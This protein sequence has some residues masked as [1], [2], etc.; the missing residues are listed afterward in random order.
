MTALTFFCHC[1]PINTPTPWVVVGIVFSSVEINFHFICY[2]CYDRWLEML[3][4]KWQI[5][6]ILVAAAVSH[7]GRTVPVGDSDIVVSAV[8]GVV[9]RTSINSEEGEFK[10]QY[11]PGRNPDMFCF[12]KVVR[13]SVRMFW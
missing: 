9:C 4:I 13:I 5:V 1:R 3:A 7:Q 12:V 8:P 10:P 11:F 6:V 2:G